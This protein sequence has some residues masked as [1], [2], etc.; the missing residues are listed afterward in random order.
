M[1]AVAIAVLVDTV[2]TDKPFAAVAMAE[3]GRIRRASIKFATREEAQRHAR[4]AF[5]TT[6]SMDASRFIAEAH[7]L[8]REH[9][10]PEERAA[11]AAS[12]YEVMHS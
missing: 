5:P 3:D 8:H 4:A 12:V 6:P 9:M 10:T 1:K 2:S 11:H 7:R